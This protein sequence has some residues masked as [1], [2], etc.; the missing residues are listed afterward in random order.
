MLIFVRFSALPFSTEQ[1]TIEPASSISNQS[2]RQNPDIERR[3][4]ETGV[5]V[6]RIAPRI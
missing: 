1:R 3:R 5:K 6:N 4:V 2:W